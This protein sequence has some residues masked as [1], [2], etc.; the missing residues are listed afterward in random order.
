MSAEKVKPLFLGPKAENQ[1][2]YESIIVEAIRD[3]CFLRKNFHPE[4]KSIISE[5][6][7]LSPDFQNTAADF[8]QKM[9]E[10]LADLKK[11]CP[12][13]H[14]RYI[15]H[16]HGDL[17]LPAIAAYFSTMLYNSNNVVGES[18]PATTKME[19]DYIRNLCRM[20][21]YN[22]FIDL[23]N[24][25]K[26]VN[27]NGKTEKCHQS[28]GHLCSGGT[29]ANIEALWVA[30][31]MKYYP[32]SI[33]LAIANPNEV[34]ND[35]SINDFFTYFNNDCDIY[36][37]DNQQA[38]IKDLTYLQ[39]FNLSVSDILH[40]KE[41]LYKRADIQAKR[42]YDSLPRD[43]QRGQDRDVYISKF[44]DRVRKR[45]DKYSVVELGVYGIH[46]LA[47]EQGNE[48]PLPKLYITKSYHYSWD[49]AMDIIGIGR[50]NVVRVE[51]TDEFSMDIG[52]LRTRYGANAGYPILAVIGILGSSKQGSIDPLDE[53][54]K[55]REDLRAD[56]KFFYFHIDGA[57]GG[58]FPTLLWGK[59]EEKSD[60]NYGIKYDF[61]SEDGLRNYLC[62]IESNTNPNKNAN[63]LIVRNAKKLH[64]KLSFAKEADSYT[65]DPHKMG[66][67]PY[68]A[69][70]ILYKDIRSKDFVSYE[71]SYLN[72]P[73]ESDEYSAFLGQWT[74]E[75]SRP[76]ATA[77]ACYMTNQLL[78]FSHLGYGLLIRNTVRMAN[79]FMA[80][81]N[82]FNSDKDNNR[83]YQIFPLYEQPE[84]NIIE[85]VLVNPKKIR[86]IKYLNILTSKLYDHFSISGKSI[87]PSKNFMIAKEDFGVEDIPSKVWDSLKKK[88][89]IEKPEQER[90]VILSS[91]FM[92]PLSIYI[93]KVEDYYYGFFKEMVEYADDIVMP[94]ILFEQ[95]LEENND[96]R[97]NVLWVENEIDVYH[98]K[99]LLQ[100][101]SN[102]GQYLNIDFCELPT[103]VAPYQAEGKVRDE[104]YEIIILD[105]NLLDNDHNEV[106]EE[107]TKTA[108]E[109]YNAIGDTRKSQ[110]IFCS[111]FFQKAGE[112]IREKLKTQIQFEDT[113]RMI[114]KPKNENDVKELNPL[115]NSIFKVFNEIEREK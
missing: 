51:M 86:K 85:Y 67:I 44:I 28:W 63:D 45:I 1:D 88:G 11:G 14:P 70:S 27:A 26:V 114:M 104:K 100:Y 5:T 57:Y 56:K 78:P 20:V 35:Q 65:I 111:R 89:G 40:L 36:Y 18:S 103:K 15:G 13:Y 75:G 7:K 25:E 59:T 49:K 66:Y 115:V 64:R 74:L 16:M 46:S 17:L 9:Q 33:V 68:P 106:T 52:D 72:K 55:F 50:G 21:G 73:A 30:R 39:L 48:I 19:F 10:I 6:E 77:A 42:L 69:G 90:P 87:I 112:A 109:L 53:I 23:S 82:K 97:L 43:T 29:S 107:N 4:D 34:E 60:E 31:N 96:N 95:I 61:V 92:N 79:T 71:P 12:L 110:V 94:E 113:E 8:K 80:L 41:S 83:G 101:K 38:K 99:R 84:T 93:D 32:V 54:V 47:Q 102:V 105:L 37:F 58:Y 62:E 76:G 3:N 22:G 2:L 24:E 108:L 98:T 91:V 81:I